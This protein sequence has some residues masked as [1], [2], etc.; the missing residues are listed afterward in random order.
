MAHLLPIDISRIVFP[1]NIPAQHFKS[2]QFAADS[3]LL[4][5]QKRFAPHEVAFIELNDPPE[6]R[7]Q[8]RS[9]LIHVVAVEKEFGFEAERIPSAETDREQPFTASG[10]EQGIP[11]FFRMLRRE[12]DLKTVL[13]SVA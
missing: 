5:F 8:Q 2:D 10:F 3:F 11:D 13:T 1:R 9:S 7:L 12:V 4:L 6:T